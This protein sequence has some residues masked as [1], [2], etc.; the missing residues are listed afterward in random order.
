MSGF[1]LT[2]LIRGLFLSTTKQSVLY[3]GLATLYSSL[4][5]MLHEGPTLAYPSS[6]KLGVLYRKLEGSNFIVS[7]HSDSY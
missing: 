1:H 4:Y 3:Y 7:F 5:Y 6:R 2:C